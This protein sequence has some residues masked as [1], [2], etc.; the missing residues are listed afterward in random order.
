MPVYGECACR[1]S[2]AGCA[3]LDEIRIPVEGARL[4]R[5]TFEK[6]QARG[7]GPRRPA[8]ISGKK[9]FSAKRQ[10]PYGLKRNTRFNL[11]ML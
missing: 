4:E 8:R 9:R 5:F 3:R 7:G 1:A 11:K 2:P 10:G 6:G